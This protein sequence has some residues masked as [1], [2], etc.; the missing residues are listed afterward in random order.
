MTNPL[1]F[2]AFL[3]ARIHT[4]F[5]FREKLPF[6]PLAFRFTPDDATALKAYRIHQAAVLHH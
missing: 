4:P 1:S 5:V 3:L 2:L 6:H